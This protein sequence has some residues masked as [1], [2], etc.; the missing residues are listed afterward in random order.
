VTAPW[1]VVDSGGFLGRAQVA[2]LVAMICI[3]K[4]LLHRCMGVLARLACTKQV[5]WVPVHAGVYVMQVLL[6]SVYISV[7][8]SLQG[9]HM[10]SC[11][12]RLFIRVGERGSP[13]GVQLVYA[14][15]LS[16]GVG[17]T[18][19]T[20]DTQ[21]ELRGRDATPGGP[22]QSRWTKSR[23]LCI[24]ICVQSTHVCIYVGR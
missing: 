21:C 16:L 20:L 10:R 11:M 1:A 6:T 22:E 19:C 9:V 24:C 7:T 3:V 2:R 13:G 14:E 23:H 8:Q 18:H 15:H 17:D 4:K 5:S 12:H